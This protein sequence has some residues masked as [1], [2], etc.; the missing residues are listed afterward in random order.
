MAARVWGRRTPKHST[1]ASLLGRRV[2]LGPGRNASFRFGTPTSSQGALAPAGA[3]SAAAVSSDLAVR[4][5]E[6]GIFGP[7]GLVCERFTT[8]LTILG[9]QPSY[10]AYK[11]SLGS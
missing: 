4:V 6:A 2:D 3:A 10:L 7:G 5:C 1:Q 8:W 9:L 11:L